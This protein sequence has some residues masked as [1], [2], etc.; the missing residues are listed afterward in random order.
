MRGTRLVEKVS[1]PPG[2]RRLSTNVSQVGSG[3]DRLVCGRGLLRPRPESCQENG[4]HLESVKVS[5]KPTCLQW[6]G[7]SASRPFR[8]TDSASNA[9]L[10]LNFVSDRSLTSSDTNDAVNVATFLS[11]LRVFLE[12][13]S[14]TLNTKRPFQVSCCRYCCRKPSG[15]KKIRGSQKNSH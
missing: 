15:S 10:L 6:E 7:G 14:L 11:F 5:N 3:V 4:K 9:Q 1:C 13:T 2:W 8:S 12:P